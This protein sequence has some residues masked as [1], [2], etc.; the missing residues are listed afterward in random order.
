F[1][2][3]WQTK[4]VDEWILRHRKDSIFDSVCRFLDPKTRRCSVYEAR[5]AVCREYPDAGRCGYFEFLQFEREQQ[6]DPNLVVS[7]R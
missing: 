3:H 7:A 5:P 4:E 2:Y 1:T 6:G